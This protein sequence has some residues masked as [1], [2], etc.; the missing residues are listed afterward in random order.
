MPA[1]GWRNMGKRRLFLLKTELKRRE[2]QRYGGKKKNAFSGGKRGNGMVG[3]KLFFTDRNTAVRGAEVHS[4]PL[5]FPLKKSRIWTAG[6]WD[7]GRESPI[8]ALDW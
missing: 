7:F 2:R 8:S 5:H 6:T 3:Q 1:M 4:L